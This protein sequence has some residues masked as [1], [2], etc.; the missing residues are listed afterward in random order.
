VNPRHASEAA[1]SK[2]APDSIAPNDDAWRNPPSSRV[3]TRGDLC[4]CCIG[5][6]VNRNYALIAQAD[7][8]SGQ[9]SARSGNDP[10]TAAFVHGAWDSANPNETVFA[11]LCDDVSTG[12]MVREVAEPLI[13][14]RAGAARRLRAYYG[15]RGAGTVAAAI[16][17]LDM[18]PITDLTD[19]TQLEEWRASRSAELAR[20]SPRCVDSSSAPTDR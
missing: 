14:L 15:E 19:P 6:I 11:S 9:I 2:R 16:D 13:A 20:S 5:A 1:A 8:T 12:L 17:A 3:I 4:L 7:Q 18:K 10:R